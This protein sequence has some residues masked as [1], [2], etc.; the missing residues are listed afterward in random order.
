VGD[1]KTVERPVND[2]ISR[3]VALSSKSVSGRNFTEVWVSK[4]VIADFVSL[5]NHAAQIGM[6]PAVF[7]DHKKVAGT[8]SCFR[9]SG[10]AVST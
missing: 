3:W 2:S 10:C 6:C 5:G 9:M 1:H 7:A 8:F 4:R